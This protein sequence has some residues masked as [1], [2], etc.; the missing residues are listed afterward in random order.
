MKQIEYN[1]HT[2]YIL[3]HPHTR[4]HAPTHARAHTDYRTSI[5]IVKWA[6]VQGTMPVHEPTEVLSGLLSL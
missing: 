2:T 1:K 6:T 4:T 3:H 5:L